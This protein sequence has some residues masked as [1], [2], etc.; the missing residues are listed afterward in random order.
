MGKCYATSRT[1]IQTLFLSAPV[2]GFGLAARGQTF[3]TGGESGFAPVLLVLNFLPGF[4]GETGAPCR[5]T[6]NSTARRR[7][8]SRAVCRWS[9]CCRCMPATGPLLVPG[10]TLVERLGM[11]PFASGIAPF[12]PGRCAPCC[13]KEESLCNV[14]AICCQ[15]RAM[16]CHPPAPPRLWR[17]SR[18]VDVTFGA[19]IHA[20]LRGRHVRA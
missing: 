13:A 12:Q 11:T 20:W 15:R 7:R 8:Q 18:L 16:T 19:I 6:A 10:Y 4:E 17:P 14:C 3:G 5:W 9:A 1:T 2:S